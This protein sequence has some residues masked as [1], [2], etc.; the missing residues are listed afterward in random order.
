MNSALLNQPC[1]CNCGHSRFAINSKPIIRF[2]CHCTICQTVYRKPYADVTALW[3]RDVL[4]PA[5]NDINFR[6]YKYPPALDR[7]TCQSCGL[8]V[9]GFL[10]LAPFVKI[11]F[12]PSANIANQDLLPASSA[13]IFYHRRTGDIEDTLPKYSGYWSSELAV[14]KFIF[15]AIFNRT[16][17]T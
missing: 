1:T 11:A 3:A 17:S 12:I 4:L 16:E 2:F 6:K 10:R 15:S 8:S 5:S 14:S 9:V 13:H 7:G